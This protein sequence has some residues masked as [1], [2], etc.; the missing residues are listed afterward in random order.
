MKKA[1][2]FGVYL[3]YFAEIVATM[4]VFFPLLQG[5]FTETYDFLFNTGMVGVV[6]LILIICF[7]LQIA[8]PSLGKRLISLFD[9]LDEGK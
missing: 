1:L 7:I 4:M 6:A 8:I 5:Q 3:L 2:L 9:K